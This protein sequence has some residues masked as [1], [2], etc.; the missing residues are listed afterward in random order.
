MQEAN[1]QQETQDSGRPAAGRR[2]QPPRQRSAAGVAATAAAATAAAAQA[3]ATTAATLPLQPASQEEVRFDGQA[4]AQQQ[5]GGGAAPA[6]PRWSYLELLDARWGGWE[7]PRCPPACRPAHARTLRVGA[8]RPAIQALA[9]PSICFRR[10]NLLHAPC[11]SRFRRRAAALVAD[12]WQRQEGRRQRQQLELLWPPLGAPGACGVAAEGA[13]CIDRL[14]PA[15]H[16]PRSLQAPLL[17]VPTVA[18]SLV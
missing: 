13:P 11:R 6:P 16:C 18:H 15:A 12:S 10:P 17:M 1:E 3:A 8:A 9:W 14:L 2:L 7:Q 4:A 5:Q